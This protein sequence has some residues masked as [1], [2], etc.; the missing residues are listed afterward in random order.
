MTGDGIKVGGYRW[1]VML[2]GAAALL[3]LAPLIAMRFTSEVNWTGSDFV[4]FGVMLT[5]LCGGVELAVRMSRH[6]SYR[7]AAAIALLTSFLLVWVNLAVGIIGNENNPANQMFFGVL[8][9][10]LV[11]ALIARF[12]AA[13]LARAMVAMAVAQ[14]LVAVVAQI[15]GAFIWPLT[16]V[17]AGLWLASA[18]LFRKAAREQ[19]AA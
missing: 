2:W 15:G 7:V 18:W 16:V 17:F 8:A 14:F 3:L 9:V 4:A 12:R 6:H 10:G 1:R 19:V 5:V 13:G 11:G